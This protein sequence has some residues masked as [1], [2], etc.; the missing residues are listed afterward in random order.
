MV[1]EAKGTLT[2]WKCFGFRS[3]GMS[4]ALP[5]FKKNG[6]LYTRPSCLYEHDVSF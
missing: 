4:A 3:L 1:H 5:L 6:C 2:R